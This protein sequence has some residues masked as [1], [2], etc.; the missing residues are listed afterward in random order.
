MNGAVEATN[1]NI[2][3]IISKT[4]TTFKDWH[5]KLSLSLFAYKTSIRTSIGATPYSLVCGMEAVLPIEVEISPLRILN[6]AK[7]DD[8]EWVQ[9][10]MDQLNL[11]EEKRMKAI[12]HGQMY[13]KRMMQAYDKKAFS[14]GA[15]ILAMMGG[16]TL[17][18]AIISG[19]VKKYYA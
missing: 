11:I 14:G 16:N 7:L 5:E 1:K 17:S 6:E 2:K 13:Q 10:K 19:S 3:R 12:C 4:T 18:N 8:V 9:V 15:L